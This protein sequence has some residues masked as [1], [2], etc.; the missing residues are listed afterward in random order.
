MF[1]KEHE[2]VKHAFFNDQRPNYHPGAAKLSWE[3]TL[4]FFQRHVKGARSR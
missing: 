1:V 2:G 4:E 3:R